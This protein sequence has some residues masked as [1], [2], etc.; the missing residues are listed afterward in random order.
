M[1][2]KP[3][4]S[5]GEIGATGTAFFRGF[6]DNDE[7]NPSMTGS[8]G[9]ETVS[10]MLSDPQVQAS[11]NIVTLPIRAATW[12]IDCED[13]R[14]K[15]ELEEALF[16][17]VPF[18][19]FLDHALLAYS[20]GY[21]VM[22]VVPESDAGKLW[23]RKLAHRGQATISDWH[24][25]ADGE[26]DGVTQQVWKQDRYQ[27][28]FIPS[29]ALFHVAFS[30]IGNNFE[31]RSG[32]RAAYKP[33]FIKENVERVAAMAIE[34][35]GLGVPLVKSPKD[36][37]TSD[38]N[39]A[40]ALAK[41]YR[42]GARAHIYLPD[43][44]DFSVVGQGDASRYDPMPLIRYC[45]EGIATAVLAMVLVVGR[46]E[47]G[48]YAL[49]QSLLDIFQLGLEGIADW[50]AEAINE[51]LIGRWLAW[52]Y[53]DA[54]NIEARI[55]WSDL[56][57]AHVDVVAEALAKLQ[58]GGFMT[59]DPETET[60][61]RNM[62]KAPQREA[63]PATK[64]ARP[65]GAMRAAKTP[66]AASEPSCVC[67]HA[68]HTAAAPAAWW[69]DLSD[70]EKRMS[71]REIDGR[72]E[73]AAERIVQV[74]ADERGAWADDLVRQIEVALSDGNPSDIGDIALP[75]DA[76]LRRVE[77][78]VEIQRETHEYG[79]RTVAEERQRQ[80]GRQA[81]R[82][83]RDVPFDPATD[84]DMYFQT[85]QRIMREMAQMLESEAQRA[86]EELHRTV[87]DELT[88]EDRV[89]VRI[90]L[91]GESELGTGTTQPKLIPSA[92]A[93]ARQAVASAFN[94]GRDAIAQEIA[95]Q[96]AYARRSGILDAQICD[97][98]RPKDGVQHQVGTPEYYRDMPPDPQCASVRSGGNNC[99]CLY[100]YIFKPL[101]AQ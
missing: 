96:I 42:A 73:D 13:E 57:V 86:A 41:N 1:Y 39:A 60:W 62:L 95:D 71:L 91:M 22:E 24:V 7:Y 32:L 3:K 15:A 37:D 101:S 11:E 20:Y 58:P 84:G 47:K 28:L 66:A 85:A 82:I 55:R 90:Q 74:F 94:K 46:S 72:Q 56:E 14:I 40:A 48:S 70:D 27:R 99:R 51:Q 93:K 54:D 59:P 9:V 76:V 44:W 17:R 68:H 12:E 25:D 52:N 80:V 16:Q 49:S 78:V 43:G 23:F 26:L 4:R 81:A 10:K 97:V 6:L 87:G 63:A 21:E 30:Q 61:L 18:K 34:R 67:E 2:E 36:Y 19:R 89:G 65:G 35:F 31:G 45:D 98:C 38:K 50:I 33:W 69:R 88:D 77:D 29:S 75:E 83:A 79:Q 100:S 53:K 64:A 5:Q 8:A 92:R